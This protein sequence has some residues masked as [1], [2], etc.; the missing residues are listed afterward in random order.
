MG[1]SIEASGQQTVGTEVQV[2]VVCLFVVVF[3]KP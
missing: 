2:G 3:F 1:M